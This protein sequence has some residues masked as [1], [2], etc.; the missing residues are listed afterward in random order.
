[1]KNNG[2]QDKGSEK[3]Y[4]PVLFTEEERRKYAAWGLKKEKVLLPYAVVAIC[5]DLFVL[6]GTC[7]YL[8]LALAGETDHPLYLGIWGKI[9]F[10]AANKLELL[11]LIL[12]LKPLDMILDRIFKKPQEP[13]SLCLTPTPQ[14]VHY[15]LARKKQTLFEGLWD[16]EEWK[17]AALLESNE[18]CM[19]GEVLRIGVNTIESIYPEGK[20]FA[21][22]ERPGE[23]IENSVNLGIVSKNFEGYLASLEEQRKEAE[24]AEKYGSM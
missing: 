9:I 11:L 2:Y 22:L 24:W 19:D 13:R 21:W 8:V 1:M 16:W 17:K 18:I 23:K 14:G 3:Y 6:L 7:A 4:L 5:I 20:R 12:L 10:S 15:V